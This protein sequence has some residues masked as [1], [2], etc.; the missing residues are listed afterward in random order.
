MANK[1]TPLTANGDNSGWTTP[2]SPV[3]PVEKR[4]ADQKVDRQARKGQGPSATNEV[5]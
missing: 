1:S 5:R 3:D 2:P 4:K